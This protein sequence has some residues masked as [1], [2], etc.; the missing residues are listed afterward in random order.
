MKFFRRMMLQGGWVLLLAAGQALATPV[1][2]SAGMSP[3][4][5]NAPVP[6]TRH[7]SVFEAYQ[8][9]NPVEVQDW[10]QANDTVRSIGGWRAYAREAQAPAPVAK[11]KPL[12]PAVAPP[13]PQ[14]PNASTPHQ[15]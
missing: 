15:H 12:G 7:Q 2:G 3:L 14:T 5:A 9:A 1:L 10:R 6:L 11:D 13:K 8:P 4:Q